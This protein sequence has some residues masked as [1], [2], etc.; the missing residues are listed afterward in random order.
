MTP[1][2]YPLTHAAGLPVLDCSLHGYGCMQAVRVDDLEAWLAGAPVVKQGRGMTW[3]Q[4]WSPDMPE[5]NAEQTARLV[6]IQLIVRESQERQLLREAANY[7]SR[8]YPLM[9]HPE[10][11]KYRADIAERARRLLEREGK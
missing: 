6:C 9:S 7:L 5:E 3:S 8:S 11:E 2:K 1:A 10:D 4:D